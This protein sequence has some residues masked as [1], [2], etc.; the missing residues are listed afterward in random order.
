MLAKRR[1]G[2]PLAEARRYA[3][4]DHGPKVAKLP[5]LRRY[6]QGHVVDGAYGVGEAVLDFAFHLWF[7]DLAALQATLASPEWTE[8][9]V[10]DLH[11]FVE[12]RYVHT[13]AAREHWVVGPQE[14]T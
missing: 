7:D 6:L 5:G 14:R 11:T 1:E 3:L 4:E 10:A 13:M 12:P 8:D 2:L 9:V